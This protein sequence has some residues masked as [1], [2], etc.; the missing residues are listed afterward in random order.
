MLFR[1]DRLRAAGAVVVGKGNV[2]QAMYLHET[3]NPVW[4]RSCHPREPGRSPG[5][6]SGGDAALVAAGVVPLAVGTDLAGSIR[7]PAHA[8]GIAGIVPR[9]ATLGDGG[10]FDTL[11][12]L[13]IVRP[14]AGLLAAGVDDLRR[15]LVALGV[16]TAA[17]S[18]VRGLRIG[19]F[20][21]SGPLETSPA[22]RRAVGE[23]ADRVAAAGAVTR[24]IDGIGRAHV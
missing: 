9:S 7:Q 21:E 13:R 4:G 10:G 16:G 19:W 14:R 17:T 5:G 6:S 12:G 2:P 11:P 23:A 22:I 3:D 24:R 15:G 1:S 8:C 20:D 18:T